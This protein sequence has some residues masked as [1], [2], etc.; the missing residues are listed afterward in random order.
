M[1]GRRLFPRVAIVVVLLLAVPGV[2]PA[3]ASAGHADRRPLAVVSLGDSFISGNAG[4]WLG[5]SVDN[6]GDRRGTDRAYTGSPDAPYDP[7]LVYGETVDGCWRSDVAEI[8]HVRFPGVTPVNL[9]CSGITSGGIPAQNLQLAEVARTHRILAIVVSVGGNDIGF[10]EIVTDC[11]I[12]FLTFNPEV[13]PQPCHPVKQ[14]AVEQRLADMRAG[15]GRAIDD[16][17]ATMATA[18]YR[19]G[20]YRLILQSYPAPM[21]RAAEMRY[22]E[23][24]RDGR[25][26][27]GGCPFY[28][29][30]VEWGHTRLV[31]QLA[32]TLHA[33]AVEHHVQFLDVRDAFRGHELCHSA[34][35]QPETAP[36]AATSEWIRWID[37]PGQGTTLAESMHPNAYGQQALGRCLRLTLL[38][39]GHVS[40]HGVPG[41]PPSS[42]HLRP[43][44][45]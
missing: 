4:R 18:G 35:R 15:V 31:A 6:T 21:P 11:V 39:F 9:A 37:L 33:V 16:V 30:D 12:A 2:G 29:A 14:A 5:N 36:D 38:A 7:S 32:D 8:T 25:T 42:V 24:D 28:D 40:C 26:S 17:R 1:V 22:P 27:V 34:A 19:T 43:L 23:S 41:R 44:R 13:G 45:A 10:A 20:S 3:P